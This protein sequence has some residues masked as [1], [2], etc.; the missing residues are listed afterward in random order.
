MKK[1]KVVALVGEAGAGKDYVL[2]QLFS[3]HLRSSKNWNEIISCTTRPPRENEQDGIN[4]YFLTEEEFLR[5]PFLE[6][7][8][9]N[10]WYYGTRYADLDPEKINIGVFNPSG[11]YSISTDKNIDL[12]ILY[13]YA[14]DKVRLI[15]QLTRET[16]PKVNEII[17]RYNT[18][19]I[20]FEHFLE[21]YSNKKN[22]Y[23]IYNDIETKYSVDNRAVEAFL[24]YFNKHSYY[25]L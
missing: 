14:S 20:D 5:Q 11:I 25:K 2:H 10:D 12:V 8:V 16:D 1:I 21:D 9:F 24:G 22:F 4:Y 18:D 3:N 7:C 23:Y 13:I 6:Y 15:R 19:K 17:R